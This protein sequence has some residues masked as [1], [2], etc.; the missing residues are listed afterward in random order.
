MWAFSGEPNALPA[1][2]AA[3]V[4]PDADHLLDYYLWWGRRERRFL[5]LLL[6][7]WEY[8]IAGAAAYMWFIREPWMLAAV[9]GYGTQIG[10]DQLLNGTRWYTY[11][12]LGRALLGFRVDRISTGWNPRSSSAVLRSLPFGRD[13]VRRWFIS[14]L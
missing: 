14:R 12:L 2:V 13:A 1:A 11:S 4:L 5:F 3:G 8:L 7:G 10:A 6:H 9:V